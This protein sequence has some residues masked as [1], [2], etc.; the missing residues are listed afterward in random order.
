MLPDRKKTSPG[1]TL[2][3]LLVVIAII[4]VLVAL[5]L[6]AVQQAR[7]SAR[8]TQCKNQLKQIGLAMHNYLDAQRGM[9]AAYYNSGHCNLVGV[10]GQFTQNVSGL[11]LL[12]PYLDQGAL[13]N[14]ANFSATFGPFQ[15][16]ANYAGSYGCGTGTNADAPYPPGSATVWPNSALTSRRMPIFMC[17][18][19]GGTQA[20]MTGTAHYGYGP[21]SG[22]GGAA[23]SYDFLDTAI[24]TCSLWQTG[25]AGTRFMFSENSYCRPAD[26]TDGMSN[27]AA[28]SEGT[29]SVSNGTVTPWAYVGWTHGVALS[30]G[31][32]VWYATG[33]GSKRASW[34]S[35]ASY[36]VSGVHVLMGD[37]A[38]RFLSENSSAAVRTNLQYINDGKVIGEF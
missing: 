35:P 8:K 6:P 10:Q 14:T 3:E 33:I 18:S 22:P 11:V 15:M 12:L 36:H 20:T 32:N 13:Y 30:G 25:V 26:V 27:T 24:T 17:P 9:V 37:G 29:F 19:D 31:I 4:A 7:E 34:G 1:F 16:C 2:I 38:V 28:M 5:L 23:G 21:S